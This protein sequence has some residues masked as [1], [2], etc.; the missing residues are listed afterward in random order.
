MLFQGSFRA[1]PILD[2]RHLL[3]LCRYIHANPVNDGLVSD[4]ENWP[5]SNYLEWIGERDGTLVDRNFVIA[6][7]PEPG[8]YKDFVRDYIQRRVMPEAV[9]NYLDTL[10]TQS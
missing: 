4:P 1:K 5:Y 3:H 2:S 10:E 8:A 7:F 9:M 6:Q